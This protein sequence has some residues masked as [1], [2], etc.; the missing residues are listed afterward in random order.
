MEC[1]AAA[2]EQ[3]P[4][5]R[6]KGRTNPTSLTNNAI[7]PSSPAAPRPPA[8]RASRQH[9]ERLGRH[10]R[11]PQLPPPRLLHLDVRVG[12]HRVIHLGAEERDLEVQRVSIPRHV[13]GQPR[14]EESPAVRDRYGRNIHGQS[15][16]LA[17]R[18]SEVDVP[19][20]TVNWHNDGRNFWDTHGNNFNRHKNDLMPPADRL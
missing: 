10:K 13:R 8:T 20:V 9:P 3:N 1:S 6:H 5:G 18:L 7:S 4:A 14:L 16:L 17:R 19:L 11:S 15:V 12:D 2:P